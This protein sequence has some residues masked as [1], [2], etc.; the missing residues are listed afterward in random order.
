M[1]VLDPIAVNESENEN[2]KLTFHDACADGNLD[3]VKVYL[4]E[5]GFDFNVWDD[6][7]D[8]GFNEA[9]FNGHLNVVQ[10]LLQEGFDMNFGAADGRTGF[11]EACG[12]GHLNVVQFLLQEGFDMNVSLGNRMT[13]FHLACG[14]GHLNV[15][16]FL[17]QEG[18]DMN[19]SLRI[20][21]TGFHFACHQGKLNVVQLLVQRGFEGI[22][23][24]GGNGKTGLTMLIDARYTLS[25]NDLF[26]PC[27]LLL[28]ESGA[29]LNENDVFGELISAI[30]I[31]LIEI[32][33]MKQ[34]IFEN[35]SGR[36][37]QA[38]TDFT[39]DPVTNTS[40]HNLSQVLWI[41][42]LRLGHFLVLKD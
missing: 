4:A 42:I 14:G 32:T 8:T 40:L 21:M 28:I 12:R 33:C 35:W 23:E 29:Q 5:Q 6:Y 27:L 18:F 38:I 22:N 3:M 34:A 13:G 7:G 36:I 37:A 20:G 19:V 25:D 16:Q 26:I 31:R 11:H 10:F 17:I 2:D 30:Q 41:Q 1:S 39:I 9:C 15:V 24:L